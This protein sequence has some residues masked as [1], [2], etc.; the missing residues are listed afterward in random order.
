MSRSRFLLLLLLVLAG[1]DAR[2]EQPAN[3]GE[4][5]QELVLYADGGGYAADL[6]NAIQPALVWL[7]QRVAASAT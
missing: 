3:L 1:Q 5:K 2:A 7:E 4:L 6:Y